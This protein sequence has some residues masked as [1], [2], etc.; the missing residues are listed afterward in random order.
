[1]CEGASWYRRDEVPWKR[2]TK[3]CRREALA[4]VLPSFPRLS[5]LCSGDL[6]L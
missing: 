1:M 3:M 6:L 2:E 4:L 5:L